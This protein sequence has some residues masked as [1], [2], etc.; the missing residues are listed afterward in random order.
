MKFNLG[1]VD[2]DAMPANKD[3][4]FNRFHAALADPL[5]QKRQ[6]RDEG[7]SAWSDFQPMQGNGVRQLQ[8]FLLDA[9]FLARPDA[10]DGIY[11]Y[12]TQAGVR[13]FQEY[14]RTV[15]G[16]ASIGVPDGVAGPNTLG[17]VEKWK[18]DNLGVC[19]WGASANAPSQEY[20]N[21]IALLEKAKSHF[22]TNPS[23]IRQRVEA[24]A[25]PTDTRKVNDWDVSPETIHLIGLRN[26]Q[27]IFTGRR[28]NDDLFVLLIRGMVFKFWGSTDPNPNMADRKDIPFLIEGQ[29]HYQFGWHKVSDEKTVYRALRPASVGVLVFRDKNADRILTEADIATGFEETPNTTINIHWSGVGSANFSAGCQVIAGH[30]YINHKDSLVPCSTFAAV[31]YSELGSQKTR[32]AYNVFTDLLLAYAPKGVRTIAYTLG[33]DETLRLSDAWKPEFVQETVMKM[34]QS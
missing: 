13:L 14:I 33:R 5:K 28:E 10:V 19:E 20:K 27:E 21:W 17:F 32:A 15:R 1:S 29:H 31:S 34:K 12:T 3:E 18:Q 8:Q 2:A 22:Q 6:F 23:P 24:Y 7:N 25:K 4:F 26:G 9:G 11:G 30:S 16:D